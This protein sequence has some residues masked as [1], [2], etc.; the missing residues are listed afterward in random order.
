MDKIKTTT[1]KNILM[2]DNDRE[3]ARNMQDYLDHHEIKGKYGLNF[4]FVPNVKQA[5]K[6]I[7]EMKIDLIILEI[8]LPVINGYYFLNALKRGKTKIPVVIYTR[9]KGPQDLVKMA[10]VDVDNIFVKQLMKMEDLVQ[11]IISH[12]D[13]KAELDKVLAELQSQIKSL[14]ES[15]AQ[16]ALKVIQCPRCHMILNRNSH[17][18][19][20][21]GQKIAQIPTKSLQTAESVPKENET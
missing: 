4:I 1:E 20:N 11:I 18:C 2:V 21:C 16:S 5:L 12:K 9:L 19:N 14:S 8:I 17:F 7:A 15:E 13:Q 6:K 10:S 3:L